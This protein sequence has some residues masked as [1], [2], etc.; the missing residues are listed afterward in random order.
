MISVSK[1]L[2]YEILFLL[3]LV[4]TLAYSAEKYAPGETID[5]NV[6]NFPDTQKIKG[7][8]AVE[9][10][11][12]GVEGTIKH[13]RFVKWT[14]VMVQDPARRLDLDQMVRLG[15]IETDGFTSIFVSLQGEVYNG[16]FQAGT[17]GVLLVPNEPAIYRA[18]REAHQIQFHIE[19]I[20][21]LKAGNSPFF[22]APQVHQNITFPNYA[23]Y[24]YN[25]LNRAFEANV[26]L[27]LSH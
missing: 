17:I 14:G 6:K 11:S 4:P 23:V 3:I 5:V 2:A 19:T 13:S 25:T 26:F 7:S 20:C 8:V 15:S 1:A 12:V 21:E 10:G 22:S 9:G 16:D 18:I 27:Y 24:I